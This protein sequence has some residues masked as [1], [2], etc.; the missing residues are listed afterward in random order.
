[1]RIVST[2]AQHSVLQEGGRDLALALEVTLAHAHVRRLELEQLVVDPRHEQRVLH[3][4]RRQQRLEEA[5][6]QGLAR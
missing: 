3:N 2:M 1:M 5:P 6:A 4:A